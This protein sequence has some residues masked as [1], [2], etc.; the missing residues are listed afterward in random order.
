MTRYAFLFLFV[1]LPSVTSGQG[2]RLV[3]LDKVKPDY[4]PKYFRIVAVKDMRKDTGIV[5]T[6][7]WPVGKTQAYHYANGIGNSFL[8]TINR[9]V[10]VDSS[11]VPVELY[12]KKLEVVKKQAGKSND[13]YLYGSFDLMYK[14]EVLYSYDGSSFI[15]AIADPLT[16]IPTITTYFLGHSFILADDWLGPNLKYIDKKIQVQVVVAHTSTDSNVKLYDPRTMLTIDDFLGTPP[17][18]E[19]P[20]ISPK[21]YIAYA[22]DH[23]DTVF[24]KSV[25]ITIEP[26]FNREESWTTDKNNTAM[27]AYAQV[28]FDLV[29]LKACELYG[30]A[31]TTNYTYDDYGKEFKI[32]YDIVSKSLMEAVQAYIKDSKFTQDVQKHNEWATK[33]RKQLSNCACYY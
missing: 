22:T 5:G 26:V 16:R 3:K 1:L 32:Q 7:E 14:G 6:L 33:I 25:K 28:L 27:L 9:G 19:Y 11:K 24:S 15:P 23:S 31:R 4:T 20:Y 10:P 2:V 29:A 30:M 21:A 13:I 18:L 17:K 12:I 8:E